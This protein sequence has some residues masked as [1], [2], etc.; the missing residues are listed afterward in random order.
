[1]LDLFSSEPVLT[2]IQDIKGH[3]EQN[4]DQMAGCASFVAQI[5]LFNQRIQ[6]VETKFAL[7]QFTAW[8]LFTI[9]KSSYVCYT[10][11]RQIM[12]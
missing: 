5:P 9:R 3:I 6:R 10:F 11:C 7:F 1:M 12:M 4:A 2:R 8:V